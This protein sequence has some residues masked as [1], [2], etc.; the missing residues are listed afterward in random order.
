MKKFGTMIGFLLLVG[1]AGKPA[2]QPYVKYHEDIP[3]ICLRQCG[4]DIV[5][6]GTMINKRG[7]IECEC[8]GLLPPEP[9]AKVVKEKKRKAIKKHS[10]KKAP[11]AKAKKKK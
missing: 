8:D 10:R 9:V 6:T 7:Q 1:C 11:P 2:R 5:H 4:V 3:R